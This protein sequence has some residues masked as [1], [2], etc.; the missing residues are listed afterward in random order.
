MGL[1]TGGLARTL[2]TGAS[3]VI[4]CRAHEAEADVT[5]DD[6]RRAR[7]ALRGSATFPLALLAGAPKTSNLF[8]RASLLLAS[9]T[10]ISL[11]S[12]MLGHS[13]IAVTVDTCSH[14]LDG[15]GRKAAEAADAMVPRA[16]RAQSVHSQAENGPKPLPT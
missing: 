10:D 3:G 2:V 7:S 8:S 6:P 14:L 13:S 16:P 15:V 1:R 11:V 12:K 5:N 4:T 9:G